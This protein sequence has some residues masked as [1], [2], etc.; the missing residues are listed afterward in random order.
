MLLGLFTV[1][2]EETIAGTVHH[3]SEGF[4]LT[5]LLQRIGQFWFL[6]LFT[7]IGFYLVLYF[8]IN[9]YK[10]TYTEIFFLAGFLVTGKRYGEVLLLGNKSDTRKT[11]TGYSKDLT[12]ALMLI[13]TSLLVMCY[14][15]YCF[16]SQ[17][18]G[19]FITLP[20]ALYTILRYFSLVLKGSKIARNP[21]TAIKDWKLLLSSFIW[22]VLSFIIIYKEIIFSLT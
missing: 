21:E 18:T 6:N 7:F 5:I 14:A 16:F 19:L 15:L 10:Y 11:L 13:A 17:H 8:L 3:L 22:A 4:N 12:Y 20:F 2:F 1:L 9:R